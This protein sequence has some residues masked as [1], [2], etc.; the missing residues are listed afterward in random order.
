MLGIC[1]KYILHNWREVEMLLCREL[2]LNNSPARKGL[3]G[4]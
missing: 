1:K 2:V 4:V 3:Q